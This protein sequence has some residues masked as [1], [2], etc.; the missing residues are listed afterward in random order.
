[1]TSERWN[2]SWGSRNAECEVNVE[3]WNGVWEEAMS[4]C[5]VTEGPEGG[6][7]AY[8]RHDMNGRGGQGS[9]LPAGVEWRMAGGNVT[10]HC[11]GGARGPAGQL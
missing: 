7:I 11:H 6:G 4:L 1:M 8:A 3:G 10:V 5:T 9:H 2:W